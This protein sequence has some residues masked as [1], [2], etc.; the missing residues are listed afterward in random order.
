M[1]RAGA[2][3]AVQE[4]HPETTFIDDFQ[5]ARASSKVRHQEIRVEEERIPGIPGLESSEAFTWKRMGAFTFAIFLGLAVAL[6]ADTH[7]FAIKRSLV[8]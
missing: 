6:F 4:L 3:D 2:S 8:F 1:Q 5:V 7:L